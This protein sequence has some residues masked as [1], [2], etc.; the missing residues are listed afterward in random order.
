MNTARMLCMNVMII[1]PTERHIEQMVKLADSARQYHIDILNGYFKA[2]AT[3]VE[4]DVIIQYVS[5]DEKYINLIA[6][7]DKDIVLGFLLGDVLYKPWLENAKIGKVSN[8]VVDESVRR[9]GIGTLLMDAFISE[10]QKRELQEVTLGVYNKNT[11][12][13]NFYTK[14]GFEPIVQK[15]KKKL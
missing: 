13:Y 4:R 3:S 11:N 12:A 7:D 5:Q 1:K 15:M 10:C 14:Y 9:C 8:F 2:E 6:V